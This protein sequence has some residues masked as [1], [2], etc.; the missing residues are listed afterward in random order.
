ML[1]LAAFLGLLQ[2]QPGFA[3]PQTK[4]FAYIPI[5]STATFNVPMHN[6]AIGSMFWDGRLELKLANV[7]TPR[8][9]A[10][11]ALNRPR[12]LMFWC[13][14]GKTEVHNL[15]MIKEYAACMDAQELPA[16]FGFYEPNGNGGYINH[17]SNVV[18]PN[19]WSDWVAHLLTVLK[20]AQTT[21]DLV[22]PP[23]IYMG[24]PYSDPLDPPNSYGGYTLEQ[25]LA[26]AVP[27]GGEEAP[28]CNL[29]LDKMPSILVDH[30]TETQKAW[31]ES[32][33]ANG[34]LICEG[35]YHKDV[36]VPG[37]PGYENHQWMRNRGW[38]NA[39][40][41]DNEETDPDHPLK[42]LMQPGDYYLIW[43]GNDALRPEAWA[44]GEA[45][46]YHGV[47]DTRNIPP[48]I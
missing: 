1:A 2:T 37:T 41:W 30:W 36:G 28:W 14:F 3:S 19:G 22:E 44:T 15:L 35:Q 46:G 26:F 25:C 5:G 9:L 17:G 45:K 4:F 32:L 33:S 6:R 34:K 16:G 27:T 29:A 40:M 38:P 20:G 12:R 7:I 18:Y 11:D 21:Y 13:P 42:S 48:P 8:L 23:I 43:G 10:L 39:V 47:G 31:V 24:T